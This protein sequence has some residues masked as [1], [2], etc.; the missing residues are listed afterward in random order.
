MLW[1]LG[2]V[3]VFSVLLAGVVRLVRYT[4]LRREHRMHTAVAV[5][6]K[7]SHTEA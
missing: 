4:L 6:D 2:T 7:Q 3:V 5:H 1:R